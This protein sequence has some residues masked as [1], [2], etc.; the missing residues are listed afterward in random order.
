MQ[1]LLE[2]IV[3]P[4]YNV[5]DSLNKSGK[6]HDVH[7]PAAKGQTFSIRHL[8]GQV[9]LRHIVTSQLRSLVAINNIMCLN[10]GKPQFYIYMPSAQPDSRFTRAIPAL[11]K[12]IDGMTPIL[13]ENLHI[14]L[15]LIS[16][17]ETMAQVQKDAPAKSKKP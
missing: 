1:T 4:P 5:L 3:L 9:R 14:N 10:D 8:I 17:E 16:M 6:R 13:K 15:Q 12:N 2:E 11:S 7:D